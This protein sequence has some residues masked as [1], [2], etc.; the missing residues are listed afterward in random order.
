[1]ND[2]MMMAEPAP[3][4]EEIA[5]WEAERRAREDAELEPYRKAAQQRRE[6][7]EI[8][9]EHDDLIAELLFSETMRELEG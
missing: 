7:A 6:T 4:P 2:E 5:Q 8:A 9:A 1:M 3:T